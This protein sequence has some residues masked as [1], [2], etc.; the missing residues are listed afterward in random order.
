M[1]AVTFAFA[2]L[3]VSI[4]LF[5]QVKF[6]STKYKGGISC[7]GF[8]GGING[9]FTNDITIHIPPGSS[10]HKAFLCAGELGNGGNPTFQLDGQPVQFTNNGTNTAPY[11]LNPNYGG[12]AAP[13]AVDVTNI[14]SPTDTVYTL[15]SVQSGLGA[16]FYTDFYLIVMYSNP[17]LQLINVHLFGNDKDMSPTVTHQLN[18]SPA[19]PGTGDIVAGFHMGYMC[20]PSDGEI[21]TVNGNNLGTGFGPDINSIPNSCGGPFASFFYENGVPV[22]VYDDDAS[23]A[24]NGPDVTSTLNGVVNPGDTSINIVFDHA[25]GVS[26]DNSIWNTVLVYSE[27]ITID[28]FCFGDTTLFIANDSTSYIAHQWTFDDPITGPLN[29]SYDAM[30]SHVFSAPGN[31]NVQLI[32]ASIFP[33]YSDT[34]IFS[35]TIVNKPT[36]TLGNDTTICNGQSIMLDPGV[37]TSYLWS[38]SDTSQTIN[39]TTTGTYIVTVTDLTCSNNDTLVLT[40]IPCAGVIA[41]LAC[42]DTNFC[43]KACIDFFDLSLNSPTSWQWTFTSAAPNTSTDQNPTGICYNN[44][45]SFDVQLIACNAIGCDTVLFPGFINEFQLPPTPQV[46]VS[47]DTMYCLTTNV[48]YAWVNVNNPGLVLSTAQNFYPGVAGNYYVIITDTLQCSVPSGVIGISTSIISLDDNTGSIC[49]Q[50]GNGVLHVVDK[51]VSLQGLSLFDNTGRFIMSCS[52]AIRTT[53]YQFPC[54]LASGIYTCIIITK[55]E[56][57]KPYKFVVY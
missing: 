53:N 51:N 12:V 43:D 1:K 46:V 11:F 42:T 31:Y 54:K 19:L 23:M 29:T 10:I 44:Y 15:V 45:G 24:I 9:T 6:Y 39:P 22:G 57:S 25:N 34:L 21:V 52:P 2:F 4:T 20:D 37:F 32:R 38:T 50:P 30:S 8:S 13:H 17:N 5:A 55:N 48:T 47:N 7:N 16:N 3:F 49:Y 27:A 56:Q 35:V 36:P 18:F 28:K 41:N 26:Q 14:I 40:V 33:P